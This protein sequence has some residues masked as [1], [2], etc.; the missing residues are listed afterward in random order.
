MQY[1]VDRLKHRR[2]RRT[3]YYMIGRYRYYADWS[4]RQGK[5]SAWPQILREGF[6]S[7]IDD[8]GY[9]EKEC[10]QIIEDL[11]EDLVKRTWTM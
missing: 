10:S 8:I 9:T 3:H 2:Y 5:I 4:T 1:F 7:L 11:R 6:P